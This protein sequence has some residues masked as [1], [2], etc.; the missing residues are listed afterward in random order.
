MVALPDVDIS[1][2]IVSYNG[3]DL[4]RECLASIYSHTHETTFEIIVVDNASKDRTPEMVIAEFPQATLIRRSNNAGFAYAVNEG[5]A[6]SRG[7]Y[8]LLLNPDTQFRSNALP[9]MK[10]NGTDR[11]RVPQ[12]RR[13]PR[14]VPSGGEI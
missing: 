11:V 5:I 7:A 3:R 10:E 8:L 1:I 4:L 14:S 2:I 12:R 9:P 13:G 6:V